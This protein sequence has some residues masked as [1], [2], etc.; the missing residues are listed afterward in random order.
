MEDKHSQNWK[1]S[2]E[3]FYTFN[4]VPREIITC[5]VYVCVCNFLGYFKIYIEK[6]RAN[7]Q[8][9]PEKEQEGSEVCHQHLI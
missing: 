9:N 7:I 3:F 5:Y 2:P 8:D 4:E 1:F 6:Q